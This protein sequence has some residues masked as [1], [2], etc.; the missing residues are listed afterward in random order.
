MLGFLTTSKLGTKVSVQ[1]RY[2]IFALQRSSLVAS[3]L[4]TTSHYWPETIKTRNNWHVHMKTLMLHCI[5]SRLR[6]C[7]VFKEEKILCILFHVVA[8]TTRYLGCFIYLFF[9]PLASHYQRVGW[10][11]VVGKKTQQKRHPMAITSIH[12]KCNFHSSQE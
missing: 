12:L 10:M 9:H 8:P 11:G 6:T 7:H 2:L 4:L 5:F 3:Q 1:K